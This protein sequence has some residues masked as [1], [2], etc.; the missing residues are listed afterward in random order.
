MTG[1][2]RPPVTYLTAPLEKKSSREKVED[3]RDYPFYVSDKRGIRPSIYKFLG[4]KMKVDEKDGKTPI[5]VYYPILKLKKLVGWKKRDLTVHKRDAFSIV[6]EGDATCDLIGAFR[7][8]QGRSIIITEGEEDLAAAYQA[9]LDKIESNPKWAG[10]LTPNVVSVVGGAPYAAENISNNLE[11]LEKYETV[12][13]AFD[14]DRTTAKEYEQG[15]R[16]GYEATCE[17][18]LL[19]GFEK[20]KYVP[21]TLNDPSEYVQT[22]KSKELADILAFGA[23]DFTP[24]TIEE[25]TDYSLD[26]LLEA[27]EEGMKIRCIPGTSEIIHGL[28]DG[29]GTLL[30]APPKSGKTSLTK[31]IAYDMMTSDLRPGEKIG[32]IFLEET[33]KK[34]RQSFIALDNNVPLPQFREDPTLISREAAETSYTKLFES[35]VNM[36][37]STKSGKL[38]P[39]DV[40]KNFKYLYAKGCRKMIL[41][42]LSMV[43]S[44]SKNT[45][46]RKEI[47]NL[48]TDIAAFIESHDVH[49]LI[50]AHI[51][52]GSF[53][54]KVDD[55]KEIIYPYWHPVSHTDARGCVDKDTQ[56]LSPTGWVNISDYKGGKVAQ[57]NSNGECEFVQPKRYVKLPCERLTHI[58]GARIDMQLSDEHQI[59]YRTDK[60]K[61]LKRIALTEAMEIHNRQATGFR[62]LIPTTFKPSETEVTGLNP[63]QL[64]VQ[65]ALNADGWICRKSTGKSR[66]RVKKPRKIQRMHKA[67]QDASIGYS[68]FAVGDYVEFSFTAPLGFKGYPQSWYGLGKKEIEIIVDEAKHWDGE[69]KTGRFGS[70]NKSET[71]L[72]QFF[73]HSLGLRTGMYTSKGG[74]LFEGYIS[75]P[76]HYVAPSR[77]NSSLVGIRKTENS[78]IEI[79]EV[80]TGDGFKYCFEVDSGMLI[81]RRSNKIFITGNSGAFEQLMWNCICIEPEIIDESGNIGRVRTKVTFC[82]E[83]G[84]RGIGDY[85]KWDDNLGKLIKVGGGE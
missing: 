70:I 84:T 73:F 18:H 6:G 23:I 39:E 41:D 44:G 1:I 30:I 78:K 56:Y 80:P 2:Y 79:S 21:M 40:I 65:V 43:V 14:S 83:W 59:V 25:A 81:L 61:T 5:A 64:R 26:Q 45:D 63:E 9:S 82:R 60:V 42:H 58:R 10:K 66:V 38:T 74:E 54:P 52:R 3:I 55:D 62:G 57:Y 68:H 50:I 8:T 20:C 51:K 27:S 76:C 77:K 67:L 47:D 46:E 36:F 49:V 37:L 28:R 71:D 72:M 13:T 53:Q 35:G 17:T 75:K 31:Q 32:H 69:L 48:L 11:L 4:F 29:E 7:L 16:R 19:V 33:G 12:I 22:G 15:A 85:L 24:V 34:T